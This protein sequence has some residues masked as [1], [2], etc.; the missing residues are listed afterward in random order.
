M[1]D[2]LQA[3]AALA[4]GAAGRDEGLGQKQERVGV[5]SH[6][7]R[8]ARD[9]SGESRLLGGLDRPALVV[10]DHRPGQA[11]GGVDNRGVVAGDPQR[12]HHG[13]VGLGPP[14]HRPTQLAAR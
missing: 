11:Q 1:Q 7:R 6:G 9:L 13:A 8:V 3:V 4:G 14:A 5:G 2:D 10:E 12:V